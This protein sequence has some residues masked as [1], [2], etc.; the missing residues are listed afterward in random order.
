MLML[1]FSGTGNSKY[2][3][4]LFCKITKA[5]CHSIE[6]DIDSQLLAAEKII[7]VCYPVYASRVPKLMREF[8]ASHMELFKNKCVIIFCTQM[9]FSGDGAR[10]FTD[11]FPPNHIKVICAEHFFMPNNINNV[12]I[13][14]LA[15]EKLTRWYLRNSHKRMKAVCKNLSRRKIK[16]RGFNS[17]S[18]ALGL[19]QGSFFPVIEKWGASKVKIDNDCN[20]CM[21]CF[22]TCPVGN[23]AYSNDRIITK[24]NCML[25]YR[26]I[27][28]CPKRAVKIIFQTKVKKQFQ[29]VKFK[30]GSSHDRN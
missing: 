8:V 21:H 15:S 26:C 28:S 22:S 23:F 10:A 12:C 4:E 25:C 19:L 30:E 1:Y 9:A 14:P 18:Q 27:N 13:T 7:A 29:G 3:A 16:K 6:E 2:I 11:L 24:N 5:K 17:L 20:K